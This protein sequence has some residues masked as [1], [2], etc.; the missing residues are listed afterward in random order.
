[1]AIGAGELQKRPLERR[2]SVTSVALVL[3]HRPHKTIMQNIQARATVVRSLGSGQ[4]CT[5][6]RPMRTP[7]LQL[8]GAP[9]ARLR[10]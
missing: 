4:M 9:V 5:V 6:S 2:Q 8:Q 1:M 3:H 10:P 7:Q